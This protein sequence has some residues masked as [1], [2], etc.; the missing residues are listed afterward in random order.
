MT[1]V[2]E[3]RFVFYQRKLL[4]ILTDTNG[5]IVIKN[6]KGAGAERLADFLWEFEEKIL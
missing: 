2:M 1:G 5:Y 4:A 3:S 6:T